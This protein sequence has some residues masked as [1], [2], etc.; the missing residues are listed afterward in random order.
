MQ[1]MFG[2]GNN[3]PMGAAIAVVSMFTITLVVT[4]FLALVY[5][6]RRRGI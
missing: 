2:R 3:W 6:V 5:K 1:T 4:A